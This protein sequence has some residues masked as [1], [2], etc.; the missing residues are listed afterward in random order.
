[1]L[2][3]IKNFFG[4]GPAEPTAA[5]YKVELP[6]KMTETPPVVVNASKPVV[7]GRK[8]PTAKPTTKVATGNRPTT[9]KPQNKKPAT[10]KSVP[11]IA[12]KK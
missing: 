3:F 4:F 2:K 5:P 11:K 7:N 9:K 8:A 10:K 6:E 1:M 12:T